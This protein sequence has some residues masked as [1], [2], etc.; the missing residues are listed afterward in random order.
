MFLRLAGLHPVANFCFTRPSLRL[1]V[2]TMSRWRKLNAIWCTSLHFL[3]I[4]VNKPRDITSKND[5]R[6]PCASQ[7]YFF[8]RFSTT[9][10]VLLA[11]IINAVVL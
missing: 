1:A 3:R 10:R 5:A 4:I 2:A 9:P 6:P 11:Q 8:A 7:I